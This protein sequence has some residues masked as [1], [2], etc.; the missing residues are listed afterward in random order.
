MLRLFQRRDR[1]RP[2]HRREIIEERV[3][4]AT[5]FEVVEQGLRGNPR[6]HENRGAA[7]YLRVGVNG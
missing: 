4:I 2:A 1:L 6:T 7:E 3:E 5:M